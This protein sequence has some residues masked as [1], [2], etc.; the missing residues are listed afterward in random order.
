M[1]LKKMSPPP[2][3]SATGLGVSCSA[4]RDDEFNTSSSYARQAARIAR[5]F[6]MTPNLAKVIV[7]LNS[8]PRCA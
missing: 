8:L 4:A 3:Q 6:G 2:A 5:R 1:T 7:E